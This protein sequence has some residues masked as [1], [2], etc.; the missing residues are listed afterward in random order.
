LDELEQAYAANS[1]WLLWLKMDYVF[2]PLRKDPRFI[3][4]LEKVHLDN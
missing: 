1:E 3:A 4:L 2:D